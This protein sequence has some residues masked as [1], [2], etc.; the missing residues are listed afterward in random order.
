MIARKA[1]VTVATVSR[2][3]NDKDTVTAKTKAKILK[4]ADKLG[5][6]IARSERKR[7]KSYG[8]ILPGLTSDYF[9]RI[10]RTIDRCAFDEGCTLLAASH[11]SL[12]SRLEETIEC[13][14]RMG[15]DGMIL[16]V[17]QQDIPI[18]SILSRIR[19]PVVTMNTPSSHSVTVDQAQGAYALVDHLV[20][21][22][23]HRKVAMIC[24]REWNR[25]ANERYRG[26]ADA[27]ADNGVDV[28][29][30]YIID[31]SFAKKSGFYAASRLLS[32]R[33]KPTAIFAANDLAA[34]GAIEAIE[35]H[36]YTVGKDI[37]VGGFDDL[38]ADDP[39]CASELT[40]VHVDTRELARKAFFSLHKLVEGEHDRDVPR[41]ETVSAGL[42][43]RSSCGC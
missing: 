25:H 21:H 11:R 34:L 32:L 42:I 14:G 6:D 17:P 35:Q 36:G 39:G 38:N 33:E 20:R 2:A 12:E 30:E 23:G 28:N 18:E 1:G 7:V 24:G 27:L 40:T 22:H 29:E 10:L 15:V 9:S 19:V 4:I 13:Y 26:F 8:L 16:S 41:H 31:G 43:I 3:L 37:A 5:Y